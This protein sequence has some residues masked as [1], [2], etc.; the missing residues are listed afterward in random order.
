MSVPVILTTQE[1]TGNIE[2][3]Q[4]V[5]D[6]ADTIYLLQPEESPF[7]A[8]VRKLSSKAVDNPEFSWLEDQQVPWKDQINNG[9]GYAS[10]ATDLIVDNAAFFAPFDIIRCLRTAEA[11]RVTAVNTGTNTITVT[12]GW[13]STAAALVDNDV[14][15]NLA[16]AFKEGDVSGQ[17]R[18]TKK[19]KRFNYTQIVR[20]SAKLTGTLEASRLYGTNSE[21]RR[22]QRKIAMQ[23]NL[24]INRQ[25]WFGARNENVAA[26][27]APIRSSGGIISFVTTNKTSL[28]NDGA[29]TLATFDAFLETAF[30]YGSGRRW[31]FASPKMMTLINGLAQGKLQVYQL[32]LGKAQNQTFGIHVTRYVSPHG[33]LYFVYDRALADWVASTGS[34]AQGK[35]MIALD[36]DPDDGVGYRYLR[37]RNTKL[38]QG[39]QAND[40]DFWLDEYR[41]ECGLICA[42]ERRHAILEIVG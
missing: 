39:V 27:D 35:V 29:L 2:G 22:Q 40:A 36:F 30:F 3:S 34:N 21:R 38:H 16:A 28:A 15:I 5:V 20:H 12:R 41:T 13:G 31:G 6:M 10:G 17:P 26:A 4:R 33:V 8:L 32:E 37:G 42:Q 14:L 9:A 1:A 23:H 25:L 18:M 11:M 7:A 19:V 24:A